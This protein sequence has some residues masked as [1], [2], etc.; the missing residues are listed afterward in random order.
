MTGG[1]ALLFSHSARK[2]PPLGYE[3]AT[4]VS[5]VGRR[6]AIAGRKASQRF[7]SAP[8]PMHVWTDDA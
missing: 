5:R 4:W 3:N 6:R 2:I 1:A 8:W 7:A